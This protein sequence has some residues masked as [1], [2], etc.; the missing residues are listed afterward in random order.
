[1]KNELRI[2]EDT[3]HPNIMRIYEMLEDKYKYFIVSELAC[4]GEL[5]D[6]ILSR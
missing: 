6:Y 1:M 2:L 3:N 4:D 5:Y